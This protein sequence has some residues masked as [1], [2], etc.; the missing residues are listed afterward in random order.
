L[1]IIKGLKSA[2]GERERKKQ[3]PVDEEEVM[4]GVPEGWQGV[5]RGL[6]DRLGIRQ[7]E[8]LREQFPCL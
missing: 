4:E 3:T 2:V 8:Q 5:R 6:S 7:L 1:V